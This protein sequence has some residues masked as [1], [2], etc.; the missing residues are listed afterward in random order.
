MLQNSVCTQTILWS[1]SFN[2]PSDWVINNTAGTPGL[3]WEFSSDPAAIP[4]SILS[5]FASTTAAN[6]FL[7]VNSD[8][9]NTA[10]FDGTFIN[11]TASTSATINLTGQ[12]V[13]LLRYQHNF[14]WWHDTRGVSVSADNGATWTD[15]EMSNETDYSLPNQSSGNPEQTVIDIS[16]IAGNQAQV[17]IRFYFNDNDYWGWYWAVDDVALFVP[18]DNDLVMLGGYWGSTGASGIRMPYYQIPLSQLAPLD[19]SGIVKNNG[20]LD[21]N[22]VVF[23]AALASGVWSGSSAPEAVL[24]GATD[25][26]SLT[27][28]LTPPP[29]VATHVINMSVSSSATD[30][31]PAD[32]SIL[33]AASVSVNNYIYARDKGTATNV[34]YNAGDGFEAG[35]IFDIFAPANL[36]GIDAYIGANAVAGAEVYAKLYSVDP[37]ATSTA[38]AFV[39]VDESGP[40]ILTA[41]DLGQKITL[42]LG[43]GAAPLSA[44]SSYLVVL[45]SYGDG[46][47][48]ND[49]MI[50]SSGVSEAST[51]YY[52]DMT[53]NTWYYTT[54]TPMVRMNFGCI[55]CSTSAV[56]SGST[57]ICPGAT[58]NL[59][60]AVTGGVPPYTVTVT[61]GINNYSA[62]NCCST[63]VSIPVS[64]SVTSTYTIVSVTG[65]GGTGTGNSGEATVTLTP[66]PEE[67]TGLSCWQTANLNTSTCSWDV[68]GTQEIAPG[69][70][71]WQTAAFNT[72]T[73]TWDVSGEQAVQPTLACYETAVFNT[74]TCAWVVSGPKTPQKMS[75]Q[76]IIRNSAD[77]LLISTPVG[78]RISLVQ[79]TPSGTVVFSETQTAITNANGLVSLQIGMGTVV[80][81]TFACINW[82]AGP[83]YVKTETDLAGG[84]NYT[85]ISSNEIQSV[86]YALFSENGIAPGT[87]AGEM[88]YW[89]GT[90]WVTV[91]PGTN[92]QNLT[93][94]NGV[95][96]WGPCPE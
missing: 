61:D 31:V 4:V 72:A 22:D 63:T 64:P 19:V 28:A 76:A 59:S 6:G 85:I 69:L 94:C 32:N 42:A 15:F 29:I 56:L 79:G 39:F 27:A 65:G 16:S 49:L 21:Q 26:I 67:P 90:A 24:N 62:T 77:S 78:M 44:G 5:P 96:T 11:T 30:A 45:G 33:A 1:N 12:P 25:T 2:T 68:S 80:T 35:N 18:E 52:Y 60:V 93:F 48:T 86:P 37:T 9:N 41:A 55:F 10:D 75:Y 47:A 83:Y 74:T 50:S 89:N 34:I 38:A 88:N 57:T 58:T 8:A 91:A 92:N 95:P 7:F 66:I 82:A 70:S 46:G 73:C 17:K 23:T 14:R 71:C 81:G 20:A 3:G 53:D 51:S 43:A 40:Y 54:S 36:S 84:T 13:V 87:V